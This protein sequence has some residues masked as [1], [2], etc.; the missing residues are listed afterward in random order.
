MKRIKIHFWRGTGFIAGAIRF[1]SWGPMAHVGMQIDNTMYEAREFRGV[2]KSR[3]PDQKR[4]MPNRSLVV[5]C[6]EEQYNE[7]FDWWESRIGRRYDYLSVF[8]FVYRKGETDRTTGS[9]FCSEAVMDACEAGGIRLFDRV[10]SSKVT[11]SMIYWSPVL[12][13]F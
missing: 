5:E 4:R 7:I 12:K 13:E 1:F 2:V 6:S 11:P 8:R 9:W 10:D 3:F